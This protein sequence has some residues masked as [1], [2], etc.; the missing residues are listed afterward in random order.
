MKKGVVIFAG[1][2]LLGGCAKVRHLDQLL[3]LKELAGE[4]DRMDRYVAEQNRKFESMV[5][6]IKAG[7]LDQYP[8]KRKIRRAFGDPVYASEVTK[9]GRE[10][11]SWLYRRA[12]EFFGAE[13]IY[14]YFDAEGNLVDSQYIEGKN[15]EGR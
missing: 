1:V 12:T 7:R 14:L 4:R 6:E 10:L 8:H 3:T 15:G 13:K 9:E 2:M 11:E 5:G